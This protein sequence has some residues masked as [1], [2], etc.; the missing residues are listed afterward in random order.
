[1]TSLVVNLFVGSIMV[2]L[3]LAD[4]C[5]DLSAFN[6]QV[7]GRKKMSRPDVVHSLVKVSF[8]NFEI[9]TIQFFK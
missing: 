3:T 2:G 1:M 4:N 8:C 6:I 5:I 9:G 7:L